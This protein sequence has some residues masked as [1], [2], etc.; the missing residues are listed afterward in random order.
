[1]QKHSYMSRIKL[2]IVSFRNPF[3]YGA[4]LQIFS[5]GK[6]LRMLGY[7]VDVLDLAR[8]M[9]D[10]D[11]RRSRLLEFPN[12]GSFKIRCRAK[13]IYYR[14][15]L[16]W[17]LNY[18]RWRKKVQMSE[19]FHAQYNCFTGHR[20]RNFDELYTATFDY[21]HY[22]VGSDQV[23]NFEYQF[24]LEPYFLS[25]VK[26]GKK[27]AYAA[28]IGHS[29]LPISLTQY[30]RR[31]L[32][33]FDSIS[34]RE[35]QGSQIVSN[36]LGL[37]IKTVLDPTLLLTPE[38]WKDALKIADRPNDAIVI[39]LRSYCDY[40]IHLAKEI[41]VRK[42]IGKIVY[43]STSVTHAFRDTEID[44]RFDVSAPEFVSLFANASYIITNSF[45][46]TA[47]AVNFGRQ[48]YT[49]VND[50]MK[51]SSRFYSLLE[52]VELLDR[53]CKENT[54]FENIVDNDIPVEIV[55]DKLDAFRADSLKFLCEALSD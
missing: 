1:M 8:P 21:T 37:P 24:P 3:N 28:S 22:I 32:Q 39:Y 36:L 20:Y 53:I 50:K 13:M 7:D 16:L 10:I 30:Y 43:I 33:E 25:F 45:H 23:W 4:E 19:R 14:Q 54:T 6:K 11:A 18:Q 47:F 52:Q 31:Y 27:I 5:L 12:K 49:I 15:L 35:K 55:R 17:L 44:Y 42:G 51:T 9:F 38:E 29:Q 2:L 46:G 48:F 26:D 40:A 34:M 41:A